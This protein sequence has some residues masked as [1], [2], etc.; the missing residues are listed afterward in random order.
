MLKDAISMLVSGRSLSI[1]QAAEAMSEI[2]DGTATPSQIAAFAT[3]LRM[4]GETADE[5]IGLVK[6]MRAKSVHVSVD[7]QTWQPC[8]QQPV[9]Q[10]RCS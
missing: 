5:I 2:M 10:C 9:W 1:E 7:S 4:K 8:C 3:A 6:T